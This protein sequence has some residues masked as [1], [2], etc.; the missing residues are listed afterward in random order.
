MP[1]LLHTQAHVGDIT[2]LNQTIPR[3][4]KLDR[5]DSGGNTALH[6]AAMGGQP[7]AA[8]MLLTAGAHPDLENEVG[9]TP[10]GFAVANREHTDRLP[11][12]I[13][14]ASVLLAAGARPARW[15]RF[16]EDVPTARLLYDGGAIF[17]AAD[18]VS[19]VDT[20]K[21]ELALLLVSFGVQRSE[22]LARATGS[23]GLLRIAAAGRSAELVSAL[24]ATGLDPNGSS[25]NEPLSVVTTKAVA[26]ALVRAGARVSPAA[27]R[28]VCRSCG[29]SSAVAKFLSGCLGRSAPANVPDDLDVQWASPSFRVKV[30]AEIAHSVSKTG[31]FGL[32]SDL[33][34]RIRPLLSPQDVLALK[35]GIR[36]SSKREPSEWVGAFEALFLSTTAD[37]EPP[38]AA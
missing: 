12:Y 33:V 5:R 20:G 8:E 29:S 24:L 22:D 36:T 6:Y 10:L 21:Y 15:A 1:C 37:S 31:G 9:Y 30:I 34:Q 38:G 35:D 26:E 25:S 2:G 18:L 19:A 28:S 27:Y 16:A 14:V 32:V 3:T 23:E 11:G 17:T 13:R 4:R 7:E